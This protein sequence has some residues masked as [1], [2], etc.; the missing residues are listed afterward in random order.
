V[1]G[2]W[3]SLSASSMAPS[4]L[5][6]LLPSREDERPHHL[7]VHTDLVDLGCGLLWDKVHAAL[8]PCQGRRASP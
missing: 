1:T 3:I 5:A 7:L 4:A 2:Y 8:A 6:L